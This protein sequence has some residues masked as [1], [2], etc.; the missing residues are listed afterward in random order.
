MIIEKLASAIRND[1]VGGLR[2]YHHNMSM[3]MEQLED[4][5]VDERLTVIKEHQLK[6]TLPIKDLILSINC[7]PIDCSDIA[8]CN[9]CQNLH[10]G[11]PVA[12]FEIP[13]LINDSGA[14]YYIGSVDKQNPFIVYTSAQFSMYHKYRRRGK[15]RPYVWIDTTPNENGLYDCYVFN[16]PLLKYITV[17]AI[18]KDPRQ[19]CNFECND[20]DSQRDDN[21]NLINNE[22]KRRL[23][24][25]LIR[26]YRQFAP[27][28]LP[29]D[30]QYAAG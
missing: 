28:N 20:E 6:G 21:F 17:V 8:K 22:I 27:P 23:T 19:L 26:Y 2:G 12:H 18:F 13:Q 3:S 14:I 11:K 5:V 24:E 1:V 7:I 4:A 15:D 10:L 9:K 29:N 30:Q 25:K 16:A